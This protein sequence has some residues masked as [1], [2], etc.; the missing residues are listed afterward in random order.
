MR[1]IVG[2]F[3]TLAAT[4]AVEAQEASP[5][6]LARQR[7]PDWVQEAVV[8]PGFEQRY[9][10]DLQMNPFVLQGDFDRDGRQDAA[11]WVR[12]RRSDQAGI[13]IVRRAGTTLAVL[14]ACDRD[15]D[16]AAVVVVG[17]VLAR[18]VQPCP[19]L[20][21]PGWALTPLAVIGAGTD[22]L[23]TGAYDFSR[24]DIWRVVAAAD[25]P[26]AG[27]RSGDLLYVEKSESAGGLISWDGTQY[28]WTQ[29]GD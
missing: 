3:L 6:W 4:V 18:G 7:L 8:R 17:E 25:Y 29:F 1:W 9:T 22:L 26:K 10:F 21:D 20:V 5:E 19:R 13:A 16:L 11:I 12:D 27:I 23:G 2:V 15:H 14:G 28:R 24:M